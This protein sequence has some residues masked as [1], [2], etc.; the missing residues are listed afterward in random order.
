MTDLKI[1]AQVG[2]N[3]YQGLKI[4]P[5]EY[6]VANKLGWSEVV[7]YVSR[8]KGKNGIEDLRKAKSVIEHLIAKTLEAEAQQSEPILRKPIVEYTLTESDVLGLV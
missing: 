8:W 7:K 1:P 3:H 4:Q 5:W 2:G 6:I